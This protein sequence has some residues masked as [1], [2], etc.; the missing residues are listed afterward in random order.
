MNVV[1]SGLFIMSINA[2]MT[3]V[4]SS[5]NPVG[6]GARATGMG[7][8]FIGIADD[9][10]AA[11][12]NPAGLVQLERPELS[13]VYSYFFREQTYSSEKHPEVDGDQH[14][15][16]HGISYA[17]LALP[18][19]LLKRNMVVSVNYQR[20]FEMNKDYSFDFISESDSPL[21]TIQE[22]GSHDFQQKG[23]LYTLSPAAAIQVTPTFSLGA[24][25]N[26]WDNFFGRNGWTISS[27]Q[28]QNKIELLEISIPPPINYHQTFE[29][30]T[31]TRVT[32]MEENSFKGENMHFGFLWRA[33]DQV[34]IGGVYK[35]RFEAALNKKRTVTNSVAIRQESGGAIISDYAVTETDSEIEDFDLKMPAS[36]GIGLAYRHSD[37]LTFAIDVYRTE[38]SGFVLRDHNGYETNPLTGAD[39]EDGR[40][41]DTT[42]T[43]LGIEYLFI[44]SNSLV[45]VRLGLFYDPEPATGHI[46]EYYG[47]SVGTGYADKSIAV[48]VSYQY[49]T[50]RNITTDFPAADD[51]DPDIH[52]HTAMLS[53]IYYLY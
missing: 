40:L 1:L 23:Y 44:F 25:Y 17:S 48:D 5:I 12:W 22:S 10:T 39:I 6:S 19:T 13:G 28:A 53:V 26:F 47:V 41:K 21:Q 14:M 4:S 27:E 34:T 20:L 18:F 30:H 2:Q 16:S 50:G 42:Q 31:N 49:R 37:I 29:I 35:T 11:S 43:R 36:Y 7:G 9:A 24:T 33:F 8:A 15:D 51:S 52:Q 3:E 46:D 45:P 32:Q 38:W